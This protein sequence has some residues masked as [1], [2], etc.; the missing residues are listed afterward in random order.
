MPEGVAISEVM[1]VCGL[2]RVWS[3]RLAAQ[4]FVLLLRV[5]RSLPDTRMRRYHFGRL[6]AA[7]HDGSW[8]W[9][10]ALPSSWSRTMT[11]G[12]FV[13]A[14]RVRLGLPVLPEVVLVGSSRSCV[15]C[16]RTGVD[17]LGVHAR[18][19]RRLGLN[20]VL[21]EALKGSLVW[22][23]RGVGEP[24]VLELARCHLRADVL[25]VDRDRVYLLDASIAEGLGVSCESQWRKRGLA[26]VIVREREKLRKY[27]AAC[28]DVEGVFL[29]VVSS[30]HGALGR[31]SRRG[32]ARLV[33][34]ECLD[35]CDC[36]GQVHGLPSQRRELKWVLTALY[37]AIPRGHLELV[38]K[39]WLSAHAVGWGVGGMASQL[40]RQARRALV[41]FRRGDFRRKMGR[42][43]PPL[44]V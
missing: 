13:T 27:T 16:H 34:A 3:K 6:L 30:P 9:L 36:G 40:R 12:S 21:H 37:F 2:Q 18:C 33:G 44:R 39:S 10:V 15:L 17:L 22:G 29:P 11:D 43:A 4:E 7:R 35:G 5:I 32:L 42:R 14:V 26:A 8:R 20:M 38:W 1:G 24:P 23:L 25:V 41:G 19:C 28:R 31:V